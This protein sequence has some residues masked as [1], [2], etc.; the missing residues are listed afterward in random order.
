[1]R[2]LR[3]FTTISR[4]SSSFLLA[5]LGPA[6]VWAE[7]CGR[8][9]HALAMGAVPAVF[10]LRST[11]DEVYNV[12]WALVFAFATLNILGLG[13]R[14]FEEHQRGLSFGEVL[15]IMVVI[16]SVIMLGWELLYLFNVLPLH[17]APR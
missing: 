1:M 3:P 16:V 8:T 7:G 10:V 9:L 5:S 13:A 17:L 2:L 15:A 4:S 11:R 12:L 14:R 6:H